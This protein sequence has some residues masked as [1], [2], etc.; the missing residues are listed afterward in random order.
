MSTTQPTYEIAIRQAAPRALTLVSPKEFEREATFAAYAVANNDELLKLA[1]ANPGQLTEAT[2]QA[3]A[4]GVSLNPALGLAYLVPRGGK[5][6]LEFGYQGYVQLATASGAVLDIFVET[7]HA[8]DHFRRG[9]RNS[10]PYIDH[11]PAE[12]DRGE[13]TGVYCLA[14]LPSG[15]CVPT[16]MSKADVDAIRKGSK[17]SAWNSAYPEM[18]KKTVIRRARKTWPKQIAKLEQ[19]LAVDEIEDGVD[20]SGEGATLDGAVVEHS[21]AEA[22]TPATITEDQAQTLREWVDSV[23]ANEEAFL[24]FFE[25]DDIA[26]LRACDYEQALQMLQAKAKK[27]QPQ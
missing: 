2:V 25:A 27:G 19:A 21:F 8:K 10:Q 1:R 18:A 15:R 3:V 11:E 7:V 22:I 17:S 13:M 4:S 14:T 20:L 6:R 16:Y 9:V 23:S 12:G 24:H 5:I 26:S